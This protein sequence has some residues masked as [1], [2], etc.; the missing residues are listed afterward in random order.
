M[1]DFSLYPML[2]PYNAATS[3]R[4]FLPPSLLLLTLKYQ[5]ISRCS[6][7][8]PT[9]FAMEKQMEERDNLMRTEMVTLLQK[10]GV[11]VL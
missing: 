5:C 3:Y 10:H 7:L 2:S 9:D 8:T 1:H 11:R 4:N 6:G